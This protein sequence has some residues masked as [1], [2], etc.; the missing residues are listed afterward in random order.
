MRIQSPL[1][2]LCDVLNQAKDSS[3][4][5]VA[6]LKKNEAA[7]RAV[8][9][10]PVL[11]ALGWDT[12]NTYMVEVEKT[13]AQT[14]VDYALLDS[15]GDVGVIVEAKALGSP[16]ELQQTIMNLVTYAFTYGLQD[17]FLTDGLLWL[18]FTDFQPGKV[19]PTKTINLANDSFVDCAAYMVHRLDAA[20]FWPETQNID[21]LAHQVAQLESVVSTLQQEMALLKASSTTPAKPGVNVSPVNKMAQASVPVS[22]SR[23]YV[24]LS[25]ASNLARTKPIAMR[26]PD[27][28]E[29]PVRKWKDVLLEACK[30]TFSNTTSVPIPLPDRSGRKV[31]LLSTVKPP[32]TISYVEETYRDQKIYI[33]LNYD[34]NNC[35]LNAT[36]ILSQVPTDKLKVTPAVAFEINS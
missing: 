3:R 4:Q 15:N 24:A 2:N 28:S 11:R 34:S 32:S 18:H 12:A 5:Y 19:I 9:I 29:V 35:V 21:T 17:I 30:F 33:Y 26:L 36:H 10:D 8:L 31:N 6:T 25:E 27:G 16:L 22:S 23:S 7:T 1:S 14:R 20:K 13:L